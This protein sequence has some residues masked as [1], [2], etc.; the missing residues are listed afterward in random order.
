MKQ[1]YT[2][3]FFYYENMASVIPFYEEVL[4][5]ELVLDQGMARIY[6][7]GEG[8]YFGMVDGNR[9]HLRHQPHSA[10]LLT[11]VAQDVEGWHAR[12][13]AAGVPNVSTLQKGRFCEH[14]FF[15]DPA[16]YAIEI[17]RFHNP[18]VAALFRG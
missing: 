2:I 17:Q 16:G 11:I 18:S 8:S 15:E 7:V 12:M 5:F 4:G 1:D 10:V 9:G 6:R 13:V 14:F 3:T